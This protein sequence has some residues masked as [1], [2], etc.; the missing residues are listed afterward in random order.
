LS[1]PITIQFDE[2]NNISSKDRI[3]GKYHS[4]K[5]KISWFLTYRKTFKNYLLVTSNVL[6]GKFPVDSILKDGSHIVLKNIDEVAL[7]GLLYADKKIEYDPIEDVATFSTI[8][9]QNDHKLQLCGISRGVDAFLTFRN[10]GTYDP[11]PIK[12]KVVLDVGANIGDTP[13]Y[14]AVNGSK[15]VIGVEPFPQNYEMAKKNTEING[16]SDKITILLAGCSSKRGH[17]TIDPTYKSDIRSNLKEF[18]KG[19]QVPLLTLQDLVEEYSLS[20]AILKMDC[21]G[22]EYESI[23]SSERDILRKF[24]H[25]QIEYHNGYRN[26]K[27]KLEKSGFQVNSRLIDTQYRGHISAVRI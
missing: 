21:E 13:I 26:L 5:N 24:S 6:K 8:T 1:K 17:L 25:I 20:N 22:C 7:F 4:L 15:K 12:D 19:I 14:F 9:V 2:E 11:L 27:E 23:L 18:E 3:F 10:N 16:L